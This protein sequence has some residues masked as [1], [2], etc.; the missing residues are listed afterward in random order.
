MAKNDIEID[1]T[2]AEVFAV[3]SDPESYPEWVVG[4]KRIRDADDEF[5]AEGSSF[6]HAVGGGPV[7]I[8]DSTTV[9]ELDEPRRIVLRARARPAGIAHVELTL[10]DV[11]GP[12][13]GRT[14][15][16][17][18]EHVVE[19]KPLAMANPVLDPLMHTRN[20]ESL[21]RLKELVEERVR[22]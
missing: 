16:E 2:P 10:E 1:A 21:R 9:I 14:K 6:H 18:E 22:S 19:P 13:G 3:L 8:K 11:G 12:G 15:V 7:D 5:P 4:A 20:S 17:M